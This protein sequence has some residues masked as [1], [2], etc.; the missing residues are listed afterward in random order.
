[1]K[2]IILT[3]ALLISTLWAQI[4]AGYY[5]NASGLTGSSLHQ[6]LHN[7]ID[8]HTVVSYTSL[9]THYQ[10]TDVK[11][12]GTVWDM[13]SDIPGGT[14]LYEFIF[15]EDQDHGTGG[16][17][18][19]EFYNREHSWPKSWFND[20]APMNTDIFHV[21]P[22]DK[23]VNNQRGSDP[24][25]EV[26][27]PYWTFLNGSKRGPCTYPGYTGTVFEPIDAYKGDFARIYFYMSTRYLNEDGTWPGSPMVDGAQLEQWAL[28]MMMEWHNEDPVSQKEIDRNNDIYNYVQSNRNPF[29]DTPGYVDLIWG[30][31]PDIPAGYYDSAEDLSG[32]ELK[33][34]L[35]N[36]ISDHVKYPYTSSSTD[37]WDILKETDED[38]DNADNVIL[39][40]TGRSQVKS[41]NSGENLTYTGDRWNREHVWSKSHGFPVE[42]D[43]AFTDI[44]HLRPADEKVN[45]SRSN[46]DFDNGG[47]AHDEATDCN[48]DSD[49][50]EPRDAVKG[51]V[52]RMM[53]YMVVR[54]DPGYHSD[55]SLYDLEL[56]DFAGVDIGDPP[57]EPLF[58][59]LSTLIQWHLQDPVDAFEQNRNEV[60]SGYQGNRN[61]F[62]D[63]PEWVESIF[64][65]QLSSHTRIDF[66]R[67]SLSVEESSGSV[68]LELSVINSD[69]QVATQCEVRLIGGTG[70]LSDLNNFTT[71]SITFP[72]GSSDMQSVEVLINDDAIIEAAE[73]FIFRLS[74]VIGGDSAFVGGNDI[75]VLSILPNDQVSAMPGL[76]ISEVM[77]GNRSYGQPKF[78]EITNV[79]DE[80]I[81]IG[82]FQIWRGSNGGDAASVVQIPAS[83][84]L[85]A[86]SSWV[87]A[88]SDAGMAAAGFEAADQV[89][90]GINGNGNDV[91]Q[92]HSSSGAYIDAFGLAGVS[93]YWYAN[94]YAQRIPSI[95]SGGAS[96]SSG[97][98]TITTL[99]T[100]SPANGS[101]GTPG[102]HISD[103]WVSVAH[104][105][106]PQTPQLIQVYPNPFNAGTMITFHMFDSGRATVD[107]FDIQGKL[108]ATLVN[109]D[110]ALGSHQI[111][112]VGNSASGAELPS[113]I[114][115]V[116]LVTPTATEVQRLSILR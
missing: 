64:R 68:T 97:E 46:L 107:V 109:A 86:H 5:N 23:Y 29:V 9:W 91:Y 106:H 28:D 22:T 8:D 10:T 79:T 102:S 87:I 3:S 37:V 14:P 88:N 89:S 101:P 24:Y 85:D 74:S 45:S 39:L 17:S 15:V 112:W 12:N 21:V 96:Y 69:P 13:Y 54:Y 81:A 20:I 34:A 73:I 18:E 26:D 25:G 1:M 78:I 7:I 70:D 56:V 33:F 65:P 62:I 83:T 16:G 51:D 99:G 53:F 52:A 80:S 77:D 110:F 105:Y 44:H 58:G 19:G 35:H 43:T 6:A 57:G 55:N 4:P 41:E 32:S 2:R 61:P 75:F 27:N 38:P 115:L 11:P 103:P 116:R 66:T 49:S 71:T 92:L 48:Y 47:E 114:Y 36:I 42:N 98:W 113:G 30:D 82:D 50:W 60:V 72:A 111:H 67:N 90:S 84:M 76:I 40:Y 100:D 59:K 95:L 63:H 93:S 104:H 31:P 94:S 108:V